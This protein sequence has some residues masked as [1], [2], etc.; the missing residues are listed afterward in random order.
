MILPIGTIVYLA[1]GN[2]KIC[3]LNRGAVI[4][5]HGQE[6]YFDYTGALYPNGLDPEQV[7]YFNRE[8]IDEVVWE[9]YRDSEEERFINLY[10]KWITSNEGKIPKGKTSL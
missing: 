5:Q 4:E 3:I 2:Q 6:V 7:Y 1:E 9:G 10:D 8:D